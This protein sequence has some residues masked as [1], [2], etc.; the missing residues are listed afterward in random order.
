[1]DV[2]L[3][4]AAAFFF[5]AFDPANRADPYPLY[6]R[7]RERSPL[8]PSPVNVHVAFGHEAGA[9]MLRSPAASSDERR[10][11]SRQRALAEGVR[12]FRTSEERSSLIFLDPPVH[13][14]LRTL[15]A[16][17]FTPRRIAGLRDD[18]A[19]RSGVL[20][21][22]LA[23]RAAG[24]PGEPVDAIEHFAYPLPVEVICSMLG[25]PPTDHAQFRRWSAD[26]TRSIDPDLLRSEAEN[27]AIEAANLEITEYV[28][29]LLE[30]RRAT[31]G[32]DL[33]TDLLAQRDGTDRLS[34]GELVDLVVLIL[35]AGH[36]TT[37]N[38]I[39]NGLCALFAHP[40]QLALWQREPGL[41]ATAIDELLRYDSPL[42]MVQRVATEPMRVG[43]V[44][45]EVGDQVV[46]M[47]GAANRDPAMFD[48]PDRLDLRRPNANRHVS[49]GGGIHHCLGA[50]LA[51]TEGAIAIETLVRRFPNIRLGGV[52]MLRSTFNLRG[53]E[54]LPVLLD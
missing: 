24:S 21:D 30:H 54:T 7:M 28:I 26:L 43:G 6:R 52:P 38:L 32:D 11:V 47:L 16:G 34:D 10:S 8:L 22:R 45:L 40:D 29:D 48:D 33:L 15:V 13:T 46:I 31:P 23:E 27:N 36:E 39:G 14:R 20:A 42:Q 18:V 12:T 51:R 1:M 2:D 4:P 17:A 50:A 35:V 49:F 5:E 9:A 53:R 44:D 19:V 41:P 37:V 25:V 3:D